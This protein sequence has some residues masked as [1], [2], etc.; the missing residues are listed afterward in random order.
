MA[1]VR[2]RNGRF[3]GLYRDAAGKQRSAGA[4]DSE[5]EALKAAEYEEALAHPPLDD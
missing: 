1:S 4:F 5:T 2:E 3:T